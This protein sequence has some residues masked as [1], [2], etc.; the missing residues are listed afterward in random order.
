M[1]RKAPRIA[2]A[3]S[4]G[5]F[6]AAA[7]HCGVIR[8]LFDLQLMPFLT[9]VSAVSGGAIAAAALA[10]RPELVTVDRIEGF[11]VNESPLSS[12]ILRGIFD[13][14]K[15]RTDKLG[16][17]LADS[18]F[19]DARLGDL[20]GP[21][22]FIQATSANTGN[23]F[24]FE[25]GGD[26][27][28]IMGEHEEG[29]VP[30]DRFSLSR[31]VAA[32]CAYPVVFAPLV[33]GPTEFPGGAHLVD[34]GVY[35]NLAVQSLFSTDGDLWI[36][37]DAG[38]PLFRNNDPGDTLFAIQSTMDIMMERIRALEIARLAGAGTKARRVI[39]FSIDSGPQDAAARCSRIPT[40]LAA[41]ERNDLSLLERH[42]GSLLRERLAKFAPGS[43]LKKNS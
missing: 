8:T 19:G 34:G 36:V 5:G 33:I 37:S 23:G 6:R 9:H 30:A 16:E 21:R 22:L 2:L 38:A 17:A 35:D 13:L 28:A 25:A 1:P 10:Q 20:Q 41:L 26:A 24:V 42:A 12:S 14:R 15:S 31:A 4:G 11:L 7:F 27:P 40:G 3:L 29:R 43:Y 39:W 18:L 32:S